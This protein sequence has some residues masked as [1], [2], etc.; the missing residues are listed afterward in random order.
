MVNPPTTVRVEP[1]SLDDD[2][3]L[4]IG[5]IVRA[6]ADLEDVID[7]WIFKLAKISEAEATVLLG[8]TNISKK[9]AV[10]EGLAKLRTGNETE[11]H[12]LVFDGNMKRLLS[13]RN[14]TAHGV[15]V[16][17]TSDEKWAFLT[18]TTLAY[19]SGGVVKRSDAYSTATLQKIARV[20][21]GRVALMDEI[22]GLQPWR[23]KRQWQEVEAHQEGQSQRKKDARPKRPRP[24]FRP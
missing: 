10:A 1:K 3:L 17:K 15:L 22:L 21:A 6:A 14:A 5:K 13:C 9:L 11:L 23:E 18:S 20:G 24:S 7:L 16:G 2:A 8:R 19:D 4:A 12:G